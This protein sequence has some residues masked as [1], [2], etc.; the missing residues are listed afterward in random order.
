VTLGSSVAL[1]AA[2]SP[3]SGTD[4]HDAPDAGQAAA[5]DADASQGSE[6]AVHADAKAADPG[7]MTD[8]GQPASPDKGPTTAPDTATT[9]PDTSGAGGAGGG[10]A[11][12][13]SDSDDGGCGAHGTPAD[14][15]TLVWLLW[16][17][18]LLIVARR[19]TRTRSAMTRDPVRAS[20]RSSAGNQDCPSDVVVLR[21]IDEHVDGCRRR[22]LL[23]AGRVDVRPER[24]IERKSRPSAHLGPLFPG[25]RASL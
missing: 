9:A 12:P 15:G 6:V 2:F 20:S 4:T 1:L 13:S 25:V 10:A 14:H 19:G 5:P 7:T 17:V 22:L 18:G 21:R 3:S 16:V 24:A 8:P 11:P 23:S